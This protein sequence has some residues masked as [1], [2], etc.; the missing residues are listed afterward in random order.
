MPYGMYDESWITVI[1]STIGLIH[2]AAVDNFSKSRIKL[3]LICWY[4]VRIFSTTKT[5]GK[6]NESVSPEWINKLNIDT[7]K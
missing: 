6:Q 2:L 7:M 1:T 5:F 4:K 3:I